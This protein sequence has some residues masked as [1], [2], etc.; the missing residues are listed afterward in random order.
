MLAEEW[1]SLRRSS[2][3][4]PA[5]YA[6]FESLVSRMEWAGVRKTERDLFLGYVSL[7]SAGYRADVLKDR[8][9]YP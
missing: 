8:R 9:G 6:V 1:R 3:P 4:A 7:L 2:D 5:I